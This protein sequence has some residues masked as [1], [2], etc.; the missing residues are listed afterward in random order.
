MI[1]NTNP[2]VNPDTRRKSIRRSDGAPSK[3]DFE[4]Q[5]L[6]EQ[7]S[8]QYDLWGINLYPAKHG[9]DDFIEYDSMINVRSS[10][11]NLSR[12]VE[13]VDVRQK[14]VGIIEGVVHG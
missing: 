3:L 11:G 5:F 12:D 4:E 6:L 1:A 14:I 7:G 2:K 8:K 10:Q 9:T 13:D